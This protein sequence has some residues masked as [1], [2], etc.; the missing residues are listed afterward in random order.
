MNHLTERE[1]ALLMTCIGYV[2]IGLG[3][4]SKMTEE[5]RQAELRVTKFLGELKTSK[6]LGGEINVLYKKLIQE[7]MEG[8]S[9]DNQG[10]D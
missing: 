8:E 3:N 10:K 4:A 9:N 1:K 7:Y 6:E 5:E 2:N